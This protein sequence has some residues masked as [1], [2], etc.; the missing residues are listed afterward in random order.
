MVPPVDY[1]IKHITN[2][3]KCIKADISSMSF[4]DPE[5]G[6]SEYFLSFF[7]K[8]GERIYSKKTKDGDLYQF[9]YHRAITYR[10][11]CYH[12]P[13]AKSSRISDLTLSDYKG[14]GKKVPSPYSSKKV[15]C[16]L[17]NSLKG[18]NVIRK[19]GNIDKI[20]IDERPIEEP[21][22]GD[23]QLRIP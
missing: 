11:N 22:N 21:I 14:L 16:V 17:I 13:F 10:E 19:L 2:V 18:E 12:C 20:F 8:V 23:R 5:F 15:S 4:R 7:S 3:V 6:T 1:L 9:G